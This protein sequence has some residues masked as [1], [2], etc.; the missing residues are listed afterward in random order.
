MPLKTSHMAAASP[1]KAAGRE[2][3]ER[4]PHRHVPGTASRG[5]RNLPVSRA[6]LLPPATPLGRDGLY[7]ATGSSSATTTAR[8]RSC[9]REASAAHE[10]SERSGTSTGQ[11]SIQE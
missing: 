11:R 2:G 4:A 6:Y 9:T 8:A 1:R 10:G 7:A 3:A 5:C